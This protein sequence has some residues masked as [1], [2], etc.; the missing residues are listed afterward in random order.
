MICALW[1]GAQ[2]GRAQSLIWELQG[3]TDED[4]IPS[5]STFTYNGATVT[6]T[7]SVTSNGGMS[8]FPGGNASIGGGNDYVSYESD[9]EGGHTGL[10]LLSFDNNAYDKSDYITLT[11]SFSTP[12]T[13]LYFSLLDIDSVRATSGDHWDDLVDLHYNGSVNV[14]A[15]TSLWSYAASLANRTVVLDDEPAF[16]GWEGRRAG[17]AG[18]YNY[19]A[20]SNQNY[21]NI[22]V[23]LIGIAVSNFTITFR[24]TD[25]FTGDPAGQKIGLSDLYL[26][27]EGNT[28]WSA[29]AL[30]V[31][32]GLLAAR[33]PRTG[34]RPQ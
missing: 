13:G 16:T 3:L 33:R 17:N 30:L 23:N 1:P 6:L 11:I 2:T 20:P 24:S 5:G 22:N 9:Q 18:T 4:S 19:D 26:V 7:W 31:I 21:G 8:I 12:Q 27:P 28:V 29:A 10:V 32:C 34:R 15:N 25:D 14:R